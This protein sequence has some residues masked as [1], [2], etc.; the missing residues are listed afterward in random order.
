MTSFWTT[1]VSHLCRQDRGHRRVCRRRY[2]SLADHF[3]FRRIFGALLPISLG[4]FLLGC[5]PPPMLNYDTAMPAQTMSLVQAPEVK[6]GRARFREIFCA[7]LQREPGADDSS[8]S[9]LLHVLSDEPR[10]TA[11]FRV[12]PAH[13][14]NIALLFVP[15]LFSDCAHEWVAP[16]RSAIERLRTLG[17]TAEVIPVS[18]RSGPAHNAPIIAEAIRRQLAQGHGQVALIG[19][20][21]GAVDSLA[22][23]DAY[24]DLAVHVV[25]LASVAGA[26]NG[27]PLGD[28][29]SDLYSGR[30]AALDNS[31][32]P[33]GDGQAVSSLRRAER[34]TWL[35]NHRLSAAIRY[36]S[37]V[38][39]TSYGQMHFPL[40]VTYNS[41]AEIDPRNDGQLLHFDQVIPGATLLG[42]A[43]AD[44]WAVA[45][46]I[47]KQS[48][49]TA[50]LVTG[51]FAYPNAILTEALVLYMLEDLGKSRA[52]P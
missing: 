32:C 44:H 10:A 17:Y 20:S 48:P 12:L 47:E 25:A 28:A 26:I 41:L 7:L 21:K 40:R 35:G 31:L 42:Y 6:D 33:P 52:T 34:L 38:A 1:C 51:S 2:P 16:F 5:T 43:N 37:V 4:I 18:G 13:D 46:D 45:S 8:C 50:T 9:R 23:L 11:P 3:R 30:L 15:G 36:Y 14:P 19:H 24:P 49:L 39:F 29:L 22:F 27:S